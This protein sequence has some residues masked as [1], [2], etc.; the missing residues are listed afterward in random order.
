M[1]VGGS[2][3]AG[4]SRCGQGY[5]IMGCYRVHEVQRHQLGHALRPG[6][7]GIARGH[8]RLQTIAMGE[9]M[10]QD[11]LPTPIAA[12]APEAIDGAGADEA[13]EAPAEAL[14]LTDWV[15]DVV[16]RGAAELEE[17]L[18][19]T[20]QAPDPGTSGGSI[21]A[22]PETDADAAGGADDGDAEPVPP[23]YGPAHALH[24]LRRRRKRG[25]RRR[26]GGRSTTVCWRRGVRRLTVQFKPGDSAHAVEQLDWMRA[27]F[28]ANR[29]D[30][31]P[32]ARKPS[33]R[34]SAASK[35]ADR[36]RCLCDE[37]GRALLSGGAGEAAMRTRSPQSRSGGRDCGRTRRRHRFRG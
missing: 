24:P 34:V 12:T 13:E 15:Q 28:F 14:P 19:T 8:H 17:W 23:G 33:G 31:R 21:E 1:H 5:R 29:P 11:L 20:G 16:D 7:R 22:G 4:A 25:L 2:V 36:I 32:A 6:R 35:W 37:A 10:G 30:D 27:Q 26:S 18:H 9:A 3:L